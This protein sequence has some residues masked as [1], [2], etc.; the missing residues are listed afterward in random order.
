MS[1]Q[2]SKKRVSPLLLLALGAL[3]VVYGD[4]GTSPL[5]AIN[6]MFFGH[7]KIH[8]TQ[9]DI[10]G[11][12]S[13]VIWALTIIVT[14]KYIFIVLRADSEGEGGVFALYSLLYKYKFASRAVLLGLLTIGCGLLFG[15]GIITPAISVISAVEGLK[16]ATNSLTPFIVPITIV[17]L[18]GLFFIQSSGTHKIGRFFGPIVLIWFISIASIGTL[19]L[20]QQPLIL[21]AFNPLFAINF[22]TKVDLH[23]LMFIMGAAILVVTGGEAMYADLGHFGAKPI[24]I[25]WIALVY[26]SLMLN[27]LG[28]GAYMLS[29][30]PVLHGNIFYSMVPNIVL[31]PMIILATLA[32]II[33]SQALISGAFS[34]ASQAISLGLLP[35]T[36]V[37]H[38]NEKHH[39]QI[40]VP[41]VNWALYI[42]CISLVLIFQSS[43]RLAS[44]YGLAVAGDMLITSLCVIALSRLMWKWPLWKTVLVFIPILPLEI[45]FLASN[46]IKIFEGGY[47]PLSIGIFFF[48][49]MKIWKWG[50]KAIKVTFQSYPTST[51]REL[52][53]MNEQAEHYIPRSYI[54]MSPDF[55]ENLDDR[56][57][58]LKQMVIDRYGIL[59]HHIIFLNVKTRKTPY[60]S[61]EERFRIVKFYDDPQKGSIVSVRIR[62]GFMEEKNVE[63][64]LS[65]FAAREQINVDLD[66]HKW[67]INVIHERI[68][69]G[70]SKN[71][72]A[73]L[74]VRIFSLFAG[75]TQS[76]DKQYGL[77][78][79][80]P[81]TAE[82]VPIVLS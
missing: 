1:Q 20:M 59:P 28:Q 49:I 78:I 16:I 18:S 2:S 37:T 75:A 25:S 56:V 81:L 40:Y 19:N 34:I 15:D 22:L 48:I 45:L 74:R 32:T 79:N 65:D 30:K 47:I 4:I 24:R 39:G 67:L 17:I 36:K 55:V 27:Y 51:V 63:E 13:L 60:V 33:A 31:F 58:A 50:R 61:P 69:T 8:L 71:I 62:F 11:A 10:V 54:I 70:H 57:P 21:S 14:F 80:Q 68:I 52:I 46:S 64:V 7:A 3:G 43:G 72:F 29:G 44:A 26:P 76:A 42:G 6:E 66:K 41:F 77:G 53:Q 9:S 5:Y 23:S 35:Y 38:T 73:A 12:I 82:I